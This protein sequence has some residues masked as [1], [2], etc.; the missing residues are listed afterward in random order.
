MEIIEALEQEDLGVKSKSL[1]LSTPVFSVGYSEVQ[2]RLD[3]KHFITLKY[4]F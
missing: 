2:M 1:N 4:V 3:K